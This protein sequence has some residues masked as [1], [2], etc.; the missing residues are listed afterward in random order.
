MLTHT[1]LLHRN[2][3]VKAKRGITAAAALADALETSPKLW[4]NLQA[5]FDLDKAAK[6]WHVA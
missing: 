4:I 6:A 3:L 5:T 2:E 1:H